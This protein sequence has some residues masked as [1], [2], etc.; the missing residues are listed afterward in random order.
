M[1]V[2]HD[3]RELVVE[4]LRC[5]PPVDPPSPWGGGS[6]GG[7]RRRS[8]VAEILIWGDQNDPTV[9]EYFLEHDMVTM[10]PQ[11]LS[12]NAGTYINTQLL[13]TLI[14]L[15]SAGWGGGWA[16]AG[17]EPPPPLRRPRSLTT[18]RRPPPSGSS[19]RTTR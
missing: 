4:T 16:A 11:I 14:L 3:N 8:S 10:F 2:T 15:A 19:C 17:A 13:Q 6:T 18:S 9:F 12:Q 5:T 7:A 1:T